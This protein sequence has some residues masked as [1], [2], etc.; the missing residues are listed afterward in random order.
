MAGSCNLFLFKRREIDSFVA[1]AEKEISQ[2]FFFYFYSFS[3]SQVFCVFCVLINIVTR[4]STEVFIQSP[5]GWVAPS[6]S[7]ATTER[8]H[9]CIQDQPWLLWKWIDAREKRD[10]EPHRKRTEKI[11]L[12]CS[13]PSFLGLCCHI[14]SR[15][16]SVIIFPSRRDSRICVS[17]GMRI[18]RVIHP[19]R[20]CCWRII[21]SA[22]WSPC[23]LCPSLGKGRKA[24]SCVLPREMGWENQGGQICHTVPVLL[25]CSAL[26]ALL[27]RSK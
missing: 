7:D 25:W 2:R 16:K 24:S 15:F 13:F 11:H 5:S 4:P 1:D 23:F 22:P 9:L 6:D 8:D 12:S 10:T 27:R 26:L 20:S 21:L 19:R 17:I 18:C 3:V 14:L